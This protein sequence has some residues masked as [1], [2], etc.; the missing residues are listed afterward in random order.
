MRAADGH[1]LAI[2]LAHADGDEARRPSARQWFIATPLRRCAHPNAG[3]K[4]SGGGRAAAAASSGRD[5]T[6]GCCVR[7]S[8]TLARS[9]GGM[10][11]L[12][13]RGCMLA[14]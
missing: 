10:G 13:Q 4:V 5:C 11:S 14:L 6:F 12:V 7:E 2:A 8:T 1:G 3:R 9:G